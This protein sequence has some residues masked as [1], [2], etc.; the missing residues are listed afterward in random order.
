MWASWP[1]FGSKN[2]DLSHC[3]EREKGRFEK[4]RVLPQSTKPASQFQPWWYG[5]G[6]KNEGWHVPHERT[7]LHV[8]SVSYSRES[9]RQT[10]FVSYD[11]LSPYGMSC[12]QLMRALEEQDMDGLV[13]TWLM[14][15]AYLRLVSPR[16]KFCSTHL[17][18]AW[19]QAT[20]L[21]GRTVMFLIS[22][23]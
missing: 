19:G 15:E 5:M 16:R 2:S 11:L 23:S 20:I 8:F 6:S 18:V 17:A 21:E 4:R 9:M 3:L 22:P 12:L 13:R 14:E 10:M 7:T 1:I